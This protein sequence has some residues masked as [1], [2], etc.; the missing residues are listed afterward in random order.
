MAAVPDLFLSY[1]REDR[2]I[3]AALA[4]QLIGLGIDVW[5]D[6]DLIGGDDYRSRIEEML[7]RIPAAI[8]IWSRRSVQS[9][10]VLNEASV[11]SQRRCLIPVSLDDEQAPIDFRS[12]HTIDLRRWMPGDA[13]PTELVRAVSE[14]LG[15]VIDHDAGATRSAGTVARLAHRATAAWYLDFETLLFYLIGQGLGC[16][17]ME[18]PLAKLAQRLDGMQSAPYALSLAIGLM[19]ATLYMR[20]VLQNRRL[21][22]AAALLGLAAALSLSAY[23][24][25]RVVSTLPLDEILVYSGLST[26]SFILV[27]ALADRS[28]RR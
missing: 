25:A 16:F 19:M 13:L 20:P 27:T 3:V 23:L 1:A 9:H 14:R 12:L 5:W 10:W 24:D 4:E 28:T 17:L 18:L 22:V 15:R 11:A 26:F 21:P 2:P 7:S 6:H 8:V